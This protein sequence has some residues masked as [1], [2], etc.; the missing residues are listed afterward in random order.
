MIRQLC[1][2]AFFISLLPFSQAKIEWTLEGTLNFT[3]GIFSGALEHQ[4]LTVL[5][6]CIIDSHLLTFY[7]IEVIDATNSSSSDFENT[8]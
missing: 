3:F 2:L 1:C 8:K 4:N 6:D 7:Y 5:Q